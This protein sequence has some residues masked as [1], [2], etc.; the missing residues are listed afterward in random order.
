MN[1]TN[2]SNKNKAYFYL[3]IGII[4]VIGLYLRVLCC[5]WGAPLQLHPDE[6]TIVDSAIDMLERHSWEV[7]VYNRPDHFEIKC[8]ALLFSVFSQIKYN[9]P[10]Y[11]AFGEHKMAFYKLARMYTTFFGTAM[12]PLAAAFV[13]QL[14]INA[15]EKHK[16]IAQI[17]AALLISFSCIFIEHS[18]YATPDVVIAFFVLLFSYTLTN[19]ITENK[20]KYLYISAGI[21]GIGVTIKYPAAILSIPLAVSVIYRKIENKSTKVIKTA[22]ICIGIVIGTAFF[23][24]PNLFIN[25]ESTYQTFISE[26]RPNHLGADGLGFW[27]NLLF[28]LRQSIQDQSWLSLLFVLISIVYIMNRWDKRWLILL[29]GLAFWVCMS[30]L[31]LHWQR[32]GTPMYIF[33][34][35]L[36]AIGVAVSFSFLDFYQKKI[37][38]QKWIILCCKY[39]LMGGVAI[40]I[41]SLGFSGICFTVS[42]TL[43]DVRNVALSYT[44]SN[45]INSS[46]AISEGYTPFIPVWAPDSISSFLQSDNTVK[47]KIE[48]ATKKYLITS[49]IFKDRYMNERNRYQSQCAFYDAIEKQYKNVY[50]I[51]GSQGNYNSNLSNGLVSNIGRAISYLSREK[52]YAGG[53]ITIFDLAPR[54]VKI[55]NRQTGKY[56]CPKNNDPVS[57]LT[58]S[59]NPYEW[60]IYENDN[61]SFTLISNISGLAISFNSAVETSSSISMQSRTGN[62]EQQW[63]MVQEGI[64]Y[65][66]VSN[67]N[68]I[69]SNIDALVCLTDNSEEQN[70]LWIIEE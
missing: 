11:E 15:K 35:L 49:N 4:T 12:I 70:Q 7:N 66:F 8:N 65:R 36:S 43:P 46:D 44:N 28:Y 17:F 16:Q 25:Y 1:F 39:I 9:I 54:I 20:E 14:L 29:V 57:G 48:F 22:L 58:M 62:E 61:D 52:E 42:R 24:A 41:V 31:S 3:L 47:P 56:L 26:A 69:L 30:V 50:R 68:G 33:Y 37:A 59:D 27:G 40:W 18:A 13:G 38:Q 55:K 5:N 23:I 34:I 6:P 63:K 19:Y 32:W 53:T 60:V 45:N 67:G 51:N 64:A 10:A 2:D 21:I